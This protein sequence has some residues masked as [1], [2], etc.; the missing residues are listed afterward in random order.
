MRVFRWINILRL[1]SAKD[2]SLSKSN[3]RN[4]LNS[5][6]KSIEK[7]SELNSD[8]E[9]LY[10]KYAEVKKQRL[11][12][13]K[14]QQILV[15]RL[16]VLRHQQNSSKNKESV[17]NLSRPSDKKE[18]IYVRI[19]S[20]YKKS[21]TLIKRYKESE[22][23]NGFN[24]ANKYVNSDE[25]FEIVCLEYLMRDD[26]DGLKMFLELYKASN[27]NKDESKQSKYDVIQL[28]LINTWILDILLNQSK[29][30]NIGEFLSM[31]RENRKY[32][33]SGIVYNLIKN[34]GKIGELIEYAQL[35]GDLDKV[36]SFYINRND[37]DTA[38]EKLTLY[39]SLRSDKILAKIFLDNCQIFFRKKPKETISLMQ[40][41]F[42]DIEMKNIV[43]A[44]ISATGSDKNSENTQIIL[45]Y[46]KSLVE[47]PKIEEE[48]NIHNLYIYYLSKNE[49]NQDAIIE[50]LKGPLKD[51][52]QKNSY[53]FQKKK[54]FCSN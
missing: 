10:K 4:K 52:Q 35:N 28:N 14:S 7:L 30:S 51:L 39:A 36:I 54:K 27:L 42:K 48:N 12:K 31:V 5:Q 47:K 44:I 8:I 1:V 19:N 37:I 15:N 38:L 13:E 11:M 46:L 33:D 23:K 43:L 2:K 21:N 22:K 25:R 24:A 16:K 50:Y 53:A 29:E 49:N 40:Q 45:S 17:Y 20:K 9:K 41:R 18:K 3:I 32:L 34:L 26:I 6:N